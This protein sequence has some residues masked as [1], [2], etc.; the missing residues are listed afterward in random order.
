MRS[1]I[2]SVQV[3][4]EFEESGSSRPSL[5]TSGV[6]RPIRLFMRK[7]RSARR[8]VCNWR[9]RRRNWRI[10]LMAVRVLHATGELASHRDISKLNHFGSTLVA[11]IDTSDGGHIIRIATHSSARH[12]LH[13]HIVACR[14]LRDRYPEMLPFIV[15]Q[16]AY[17][18]TI[19]NRLVVVES[20][21][22]GHVLSHTTIGTDMA[23]AKQALAAI[24]KLHQLSARKLPTEAVQEYVQ[25]R[26][27]PARPI[28]EVL[29][30]A[31]T[32]T[33]IIAALLNSLT[34]SPAVTTGFTHGDFWGGNVL[35]L[36]P[37]GNPTLSGVI[38][39][40]TYQEHGI[41]EEDILTWL[42]YAHPCRMHGFVVATLEAPLIVAN[43][44]QQLYGARPNPHLD[45]ADLT[46]YTWM[47]F[48][49]DP[50]ART[51][52]PD[53]RTPGRI[54]DILPTIIELQER[55][56]PLKT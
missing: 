45:I 29:G 11:K 5:R 8:R 12:Y 22:T 47:K 3:P 38:D 46:V 4:G 1:E 54:P 31:E 21:V 40:E 34:S 25:E 36:D 19:H 55:W 20:V 39:W 42:A 52:N 23:T 43:Q 18:G 28:F 26:L 30:H 9:E 15:P 16:P 33:Q 35:F 14:I 7:L 13:R 2:P 41:P 6:K 24:G 10:L 44:I 27:A 32:Y 51:R 53:L 49:A 17:V 48:V 50:A 56:L 37:V